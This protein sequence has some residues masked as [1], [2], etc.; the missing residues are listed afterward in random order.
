[1]KMSN[2]IHTIECTPFVKNIWERDGYKEISEDEENELTWQELKTLA[3][4]KGI[5]TKGMKKEEILEA[6]K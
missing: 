6:L 5:N 3:K 4:E 2:C 1:M